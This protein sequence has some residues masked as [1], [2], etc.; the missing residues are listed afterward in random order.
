MAET[1]EPQAF[2][3]ARRRDD[4]GRHETGIQRLDRNWGEL[5]QEVRVTQTGVQLLTGFLL[6]LPFQQR[7]TTLDDVQ[8]DIY[9]TDVTLAMAAT[10]LL[11]APVLMHRLLFREHQR[12]LTVQWAHRCAILGAGLFGAALIGVATLIFDI[13]AGPGPAVTIGAAVALLVLALWVVTP[14]LAHRRAANAHAA[15]EGRAVPDQQ[16]PSEHR[17][18]ICHVELGRT[19]GNDSTSTSR[20]VCRSAETHVP[21]RLPHGR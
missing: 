20:T 9:L 16:D 1:N 4:A 15:T 12:R 10:A 8:Q 11:V 7:F 13:V 17:E 21:R 6:T 14:W 2:C 19:S 3:E 5:L 18:P